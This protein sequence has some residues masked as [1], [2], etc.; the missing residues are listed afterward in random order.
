ML[1]RGKLFEV[2]TQIK[3]SYINYLSQWEVENNSVKMF[4]TYCEKILKNLYIFVL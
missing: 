1:Y 2:L 3:I 4:L